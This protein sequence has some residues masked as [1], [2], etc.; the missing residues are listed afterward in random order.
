MGTRTRAYD[1]RMTDADRCPGVLRPHLA[2]DGLL[3]RLRIPGGRTTGTALVAL[4]ELAQ[5]HG[6]GEL[7]LTTR[8]GLQ[9]RGLQDPVPAEL[10][11]DLVTLGFLPSA[12]HDRV[13]NI[14]ASPLTGL[15]TD[16]TDL[17]RVIGDLDAALTS[18]DDLAELPGRF[19]F[20]L[21]D[22][23]G[24]VSAL[25]FDLGY[26]ARST[27]QG[28][29]LLGSPRCV[30]DVAADGAVPLLILFARRFMATASATPGRIWHVRD[31]PGWAEGQAQRIV[32][33]VPQPPPVE[34]PLGIVAGAASVHVPL[35][36][37]TPNQAAAVGRVAGSGPVVITPWRGLVIPEAGARLPILLGSGLVAD[38][39]SGWALVSACVGAPYCARTTLDTRAAATDL[40]RAGGTQRV[41]VSGCERRCGAPSVPHRE[42]VAS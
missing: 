40:V 18:D 11:A 38:H 17:R 25:P 33:D 41:H 3:I 28:E 4:S 15:F 2:E 13:R 29:V 7:Q 20:G 21:D 16:R 34:T 35:G 42:L 27:G 23:T 31:L 14:V 26:R 9:I 1:D 32:D 12:R 30:V 39:A 22:G 37:L 5:R 8:S 19:L 36:L 24:D 6:N 10:V